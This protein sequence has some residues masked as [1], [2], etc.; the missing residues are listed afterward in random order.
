MARAGMWSVFALFPAC[1]DDTPGTETA[2]DP[3][4]TTAGTTEDT[5]PA[6]ETQAATESVG[7]T[8]ATTDATTSD[9]TTSNATTSDATTSDASTS[10]ATT[11]A[12]T[13]GSETGPT[14]CCEPM[15]GPPCIEG[16]TCCIDGTWACNEGGGRPTCDEGVLCESPDECCDQDMAP[17]CPPYTSIT[18]CLDGWQCLGPAESCAPGLVCE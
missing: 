9:A 7:A 15:D 4:A 2:S 16:A 1:A 6:S 17:D 10:S 12:E 11:G 3:Q 13:T 14:T 18:C 5:T 8:T